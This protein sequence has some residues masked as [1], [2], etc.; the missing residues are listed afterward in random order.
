[1][2]W[3]SK[4]LFGC[5]LVPKKWGIEFAIRVEQFSNTLWVVKAPTI[6]SLTLEHLSSQA[7]T[8][9]IQYIQKEQADTQV[10]E[11][12]A[13][14][15]SVHSGASWDTCAFFSYTKEKVPFFLF[16]SNLLVILLP[17]HQIFQN[18]LISNSW[19]NRILPCLPQLQMT[20][21]KIPAFHKQNIDVAYTCS[22]CI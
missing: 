15:A 10:A 1:M 8:Q 20:S 6:I 13:F 4:I 3:A 2:N 9:R 18:K 14:W 12:L 17:F 5:N 21:Q 19:G 7:E 11:F 16:L 22:S